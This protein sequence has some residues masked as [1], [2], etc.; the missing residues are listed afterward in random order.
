MKKIALFGI[1]LLCATTSFSSYA[2]T[3]RA[4]SGQVVYMQV[5]DILQVNSTMY[6]LDSFDDLSQKD[7]FWMRP[8]C[9]GSKMCANFIMRIT[10]G[11]EDSGQRIE[12]L[13]ADGHGS[14]VVIP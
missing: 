6:T 5:K 1:G 14:L 9:S 4:Q 12:V 8:V 2:A 11:V 10:V 13:K 3:L 7:S